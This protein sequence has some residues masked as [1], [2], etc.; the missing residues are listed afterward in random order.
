MDLGIEKRLKAEVEAHELKSRELQGQVV[1][2]T[3]EQALLAATL[4][5]TQRAASKAAIS[6][7]ARLVSWIFGDKLLWL[8]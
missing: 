8:I 6:A 4:H 3:A 7:D 5:C 1:S 2:L